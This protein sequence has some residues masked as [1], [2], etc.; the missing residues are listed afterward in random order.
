MLILFVYLLYIIRAKGPCSD[1]NKVNPSWPSRV[2]PSLSPS[3]HLCVCSTGLLPSRTISI[4]ILG[5]R[6][7]FILTSWLPIPTSCF[8]WPLHCSAHV[9]CVCRHYSVII[10]CTGSQIVLSNIICVT[11]VCYYKTVEVFIRF[12]RIAPLHLSP[13]VIKFSPIIHNGYSEMA[14]VLTRILTQTETLRAGPETSS[15][16]RRRKTRSKPE[17][18]DTLII[19]AVEDYEMS[20]SQFCLQ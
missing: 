18:A 4:T 15:D 10:S 1:T 20:C 5:Q 13:G 3:K 12:F 8:L 17:E 16:F 19:P 6:S 14:E 9:L 11:E 2:R 7:I